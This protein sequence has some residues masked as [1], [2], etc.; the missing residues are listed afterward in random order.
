MAV[1]GVDVVVAD[2]VGEAGVLAAEP[3]AVAVGGQGRGRRRAQGERG[4][5]QARAAQEPA[6]GDALRV[7]GG[8]GDGRVGPVGQLLLGHDGSSRVR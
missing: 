3:F 6:A 1:D 7:E 8:G 2:E 5:E 4:A